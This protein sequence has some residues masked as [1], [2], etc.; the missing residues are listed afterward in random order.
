MYL[1]LFLLNLL[2]LPHK[3]QSFRIVLL[4][5]HLFIIQYHFVLSESYSYGPVVLFPSWGFLL[6]FLIIVEAAFGHM[7]TFILYTLTSYS[8]SS[9]APLKWCTP[10]LSPSCFSKRFPWPLRSLKKLQMVP[11]IHLSKIEKVLGVFRWDG[12]QGSLS[13]KCKQEEHSLVQSMPSII[14]NT[15]P[16]MS[17]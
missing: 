17:D 4:Q 8:V 1:F 3:Q 5:H 9:P 16:W 12:C 14:Q 7:P 13:I 6:R 2:Q 15:E 10:H 11:D